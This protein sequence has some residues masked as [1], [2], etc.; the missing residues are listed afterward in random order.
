M[1]TDLEKKPQD[2]RSPQDLPDPEERLPELIIYSRAPIFYWWPVW[3]IGYVLALITLIGGQHVPIPGRSETDLVHPSQNLGIV[4]CLVLFLVIVFTNVTVRGKASIIVIL[5]VTLISVLF[6]LFDWWEP[7]L[8]FIPYLS[9]RMNVGFYLTISTLILIMWLFSVLIYDRLSF[10]R[11]RP[12]Q[13]TR[14]HLIGG[15]ERSYDTRGLVFEKRHED[16]FRHWILGLGSG[17]V[18][19]MTSGA[20]HEELQIHNVLFVDSKVRQIQKMIAV[21]PDDMLHDND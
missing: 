9:V 6:A 5:A 13:I 17:D 12:G 16:F 10:W 11:V 19:L 4:F 20:K 18:I 2:N 1:A 21:K 14:E 8:Q 3:L 15:G 7:I